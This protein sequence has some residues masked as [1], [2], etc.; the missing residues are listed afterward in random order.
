MSTQ[1]E[2][3]TFIYA[4]RAEGVDPAALAA[5]QADGQATVLGLGST[6]LQDGVAT[7]VQLEGAQQRVAAAAP[8]PLQ[9][10]R[11]GHYEIER[12]LG[13]GGMGEVY[14]VRDPTTGGRF[15]AKRLLGLAGVE[16]RERF[17]R[18]ARVL[19]L[20]DHPYVG[21]VYA[22]E[23]AGA[24]PFFVL[25]YYPGGTL[26]ERLKAGPLPDEEARELLIKLCEAVG[27]A[28]DK[29]ILH[30]DLKPAN[31][32]FDDTG[33][34]R[35]VDFGLGLAQLATA[36]RLTEAGQILG[37]P[38]YMA[39]EQAENIRQADERSD[40][41]GLGAILYAC[42]TARSPI[43][44]QGGVFTTLRKVLEGNIEP[45]SS[46]R[47]VDRGLEAVCMRALAKDPAQ[48]YASPRELRDALRALSQPRAR[49][50]WGAIVGG[51]AAGLCVALGLF[52]AWA[53]WQGAPVEEP[54]VA[55]ASDPPGELFARPQPTPLADPAAVWRNQLLRIPADDPELPGL[56]LEVLSQ[57]ETFTAEVPRG[58]TPKPVWEGWYVAWLV[59][60]RAGRMLKHPCAKLEEVRGGQLQGL[61]I[62]LD[63]MK[64]WGNK[65]E[66]GEPCE[67]PKPVEEAAILRGLDA[68]V[69]GFNRVGGP[70]QRQYATVF[71]EFAVRYLEGDRT[72]VL[73]PRGQ[74]ALRFVESWHDVL[75]PGHSG[76]QVDVRGQ[77]PGLAGWLLAIGDEAALFSLPPHL[78]LQMLESAKVRD[79]K[80]GPVVTRR[81]KTWLERVEQDPPL[82]YAWTVD[83]CAQLAGQLLQF[84]GPG[85]VPQTEL[86]RRVLAAARRFPLGPDPVEVDQRLAFV[87]AQIAL[88]E[89]RLD[90][91][92]GWARRVGTRTPATRA[93]GAAVLLA[94]ARAVPA[95]APREALLDEAA[96]LL[97]RDMAV[98]R[99]K[100]A[101]T[102][103]LEALRGEARDLSLQEAWKRAYE[104]RRPWY[105]ELLV[106]PWYLDYVP[107]QNRFPS[108]QRPHEQKLP[109][110]WLPSPR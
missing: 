41:Y 85:Q 96:E 104:L 1:D 20:L 61:V 51:V 49:S 70:V 10:Q 81:V 82:R 98:Y 21:R 107:L 42:L 48:R 89:G 37:T 58:E 22:T 9:V 90:D 27:A 2:L 24:T 54:E 14:L 83:A 97:Q 76:A 45:P 103:Q 105:E 66:Q 79:V 7:L 78:L 39:P 23:F 56:A 44:P 33:E 59:E 17:E 57:I 71:G 91:A 13:S 40:V 46:I 26:G 35:L 65:A 84:P 5:A 92:A 38:A 28:H 55:V 75:Q 95:G 32:L 87:E 109:V 29:G 47:A 19:A 63:G 53:T 31:V 110:L 43:T 72:D 93:L 67:I 30:R 94:R 16:T 50:S 77:A 52:A 74:L 8:Q 108:M 101:L 11:L 62:L 69:A 34:P 4:L 80:F 73:G 18:E 15:A 88:C 64:L 100:V 68:W 25:G 12:R 102:V 106:L 36:P 86:A 6:L 3:T 60:I 99:S